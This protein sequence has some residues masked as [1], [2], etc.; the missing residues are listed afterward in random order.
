[1]G[2]KKSGPN[3]ALWF[4]P[5]WCDQVVLLAVKEAYFL[6]VGLSHSSRRASQQGDGVLFSYTP[7][8]SQRP[9]KALSKQSCSIS[10]IEARSLLPSCP[11][12]KSS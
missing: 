5:L 3:S 1:M 4:L 9:G 10:Y 8:L 7:G 11:R 2:A 6:L 12:S